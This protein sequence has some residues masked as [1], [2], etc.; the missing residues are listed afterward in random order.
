[1]NWRHGIGRVI[2]QTKYKTPEFERISLT[3]RHVI[4]TRRKVE[5]Q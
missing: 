3:V 5:Q 2:D 4:D 1:M